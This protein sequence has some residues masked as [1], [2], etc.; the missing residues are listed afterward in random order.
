MILKATPQE[1]YLLNSLQFLIDQL[2]EEIVFPIGFR[3]T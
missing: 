1:V 2:S 3:E